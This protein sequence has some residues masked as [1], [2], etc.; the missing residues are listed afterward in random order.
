VFDGEEITVA[1]DCFNNGYTYKVCSV[2]N[3][4]YEYNVTVTTGHENIATSI[5]GKQVTM[6]C[7]YCGL[8]TSFTV[9][10]D[11]MSY[12]DKIMELGIS[13]SDK[14]SWNIDEESKIDIY[15]NGGIAS[16]VSAIIKSSSKEFTHMYAANTDYGK[17]LLMEGGKSSCETYIDIVPGPVNTNTFFKGQS[18]V[19]EFDYMRG[20]PGANGQYVNMSVGLGWRSGPITYT[21]WGTLTLKPNGNVQL[22]EYGHDGRGKNDF[23]DTK[24][25][26]TEKGKLYNLAVHHNINTNTITLYVNGVKWDECQ[27]LASVEDSLSFGV[28][29]I[30]FWCGG[31][32]QGSQTYIDNYMH[33]AAEKEP[34]CVLTTGFSGGLDFDGPITLEDELG[35]PMLDEFNV[36]EKG[37]DAQMI[38]PA[39]IAAGLGKQKYTL[40]FTLNAETLKAGTILSG[41][42]YGGGYPRYGDILTTDGEGNF[43]V[44][45]ILIHTAGTDNVK[46]TLAFDDN[47]STLTAY[48]NGQAVHGTIDYN[49]EY[50]DNEG[51]IRSFTFVNDCGT[52]TVSGLK[53][54]TGNDVQ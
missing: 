7:K 37:H 46:I 27:F 15:G 54:Y 22:S 50:A 45:G 24:E 16:G 1:P 4:K 26:V 20:E 48:V 5:E 42:K 21:N 34:V 53:M 13:A 51:V 14:K 36:L 18:F 41:E 49:G 40:E 11:M 25:F 44:F 38:I 17:M 28:T 47:A 32:P 52:Y 10:T 3:Q 35:I 33:Y 23:G 6:V 12:Q 8:V 30:R 31:L 19:Y 2:C 29:H 9:R 39:D 43:Y